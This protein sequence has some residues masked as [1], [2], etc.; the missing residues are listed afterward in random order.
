M[1]LAGGYFLRRGVI[2]PLRDLAD[3]AERFSQGSLDV[4]LPVE[5]GDELGRL[6]ASLQAAAV[7]LQKQYG[8]LERRMADRAR[9]LQTSIEVGRRL[10]TIHDVRELVAAVVQQI[11]SAFGYYHVHIYLLDP[12]G[13][14]LV[15][16]GGTGEPGRTMLVHGHSLGREQGLVGLAARRN[17]VVLAPDTRADPNWLPNPLLPGTNAEI[18]VPISYGG[19][20]S[21]VLDVQHDVAGGLGEDDAILLQAIAGQ[22]AVAL[23]NAR[24]LEK[25]RQHSRQAAMANV[26]SQ[27]IRRATSVEEVLQ[28]AARELGQAL[29]SERARVQ[30]RAAPYASDGSRD[31]APRAVAEE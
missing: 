31:P 26:I 20:L 23:Q 17:S 28:L 3:R 24:L 15:L 30:L 16:V 14:K 13:E 22:V 29:G 5:R 9:A 19:E 21:G 12:D 10:S 6:A 1:A 25:T 27:R 18:A 11:Q 8:G 2:Q 4:S 7:T